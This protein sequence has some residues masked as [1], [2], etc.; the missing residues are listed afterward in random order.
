MSGEGGE[1]SIPQE[2]NLD[3]PKSP[4]VQKPS[5]D[6]I[7]IFGQGPVI[8]K[9]TRMKAGDIKKGPGSEDTNFWSK[10]LAVATA[11]L[12]RQHLAG[13]NFVLGGKTGGD[14]YQSEA[15]LI[16]KEMIADGVNEDAI[17]LEDESRNTLD[18]LV[19]VLNKYI[20]K[21]PES[22]KNLGI[23]TANYHLPRTKLLMRLFDIPYKEAF[24]AEE[25]MRYAARGGKEAEEW[26]QKALL[27]VERKLD[28][29]EAT[30]NPVMPKDEKLK[31]FYQQKLGEEQKDVTKRGQD[32]D[33][34][35][36]A[37]LKVPE[38]WLGY[39]GKLDNSQRIRRILVKQDQ[40]VL[41]EKFG[42]D[43]SSDADATLKSKLLS[44]K[45]IV[46]DQNKLAG[47]AWAPETVQK[48][49]NSVNE[50][51]KSPEKAKETRVWFFRHAP[52]EWNREHR[53][54]G[55]IQTDI[56]EDG[57]V[58]YLESADAKRIPKPDM[59]VVSTLRRSSQT[60]NALKKYL[61][62]GEVEMVENPAFAERRWGP[63]MEE[64]TAEEARAALLRDPEMVKKYPTLATTTN[65]ESVWND[66]LDFTPPGGESRNDVKRRVDEG[67]KGLAEEYPGKNVLLVTHHQVL[68]SQGLDGQS[69][70]TLTLKKDS[71]GNV[72]MGN[73]E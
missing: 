51:S 36:M 52:T 46:P 35:T 10:D 1:V 54:Q 28:M 29:V 60:A 72:I 11:I 23:L 13:V 42:I 41:K 64:K 32:E 4:E 17:K 66:M 16:A 26:D 9:E 3:A 5:L 65:L 73:E 57:V 40:G 2:V 14:E 21:D 50:R 58:P 38:Y 45:R 12:D 71:N 25:V 34:W 70:S 15:E 47:Q 30:R 18:N 61:N 27:E 33:V 31:S 22:Y 7:L 67:L 20:D 6:A 37:L 19:F 43:L 48:L 56:I 44:I 39:V 49:E 53:I 24:S 59:I 68:L 8:E 69:V 55:N 63:L 62:W